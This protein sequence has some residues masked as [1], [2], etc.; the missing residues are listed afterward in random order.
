VT[1][2]RIIADVVVEGAAA[3]SVYDNDG[4]GCYLFT[5][6]GDGYTVGQSFG[7]VSFSAFVDKLVAYRDLVLT[8]K[9]ATL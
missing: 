9:E 1:S 6:P 2:S 3:L 8:M 5:A 7:F 4:Q